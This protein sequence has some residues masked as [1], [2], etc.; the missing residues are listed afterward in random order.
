VYLKSLFDYYS[1][2]IAISDRLGAF[3]SLYM[4]SLKTAGKALQSTAD[5]R[6]LDVFG[7]NSLSQIAFHHVKATSD[8]IKERFVKL[9]NSISLTIDSLK[10]DISSLSELSDSDPS[11]A[12]NVDP[13]IPDTVSV[14]LLLLIPVYG[15][16]LAG[17]VMGNILNLRNKAGKFIMCST[18]GQPASQ[19]HFLNCPLISEER[20]SLLSL[21]PKE[22]LIN[23][24]IRPD[25]YGFYWNLKNLVLA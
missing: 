13:E 23:Y 3:K 7:I 12:F 11:S 19:L 25:L 10:K 21:I 15:K 2:V 5:Q 17:L 6:V 24:K 9:H 4:T 20:Q 8:K 18:C 14:D 16:T 22:S 1:P